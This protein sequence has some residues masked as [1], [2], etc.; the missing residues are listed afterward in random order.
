MKD[1]NFFSTYNNKNKKI[2]GPV[3]FFYGAL[4]LVIIG[5]IAYGIF[6]FMTIMRLNKDLSALEVELKTIKG[7]PKLSVILNKGNDLKAMKDDLSKLRLID[8]HMKDRDFISEF[9]LEDVR[10]A[11]PPEIFLESMEMSKGS[12]EIEGRSKNKEAIA[13]FEHNLRKIEEF[14]KVFVTH[15]IGDEGYYGFNLNIDMKEELPDGTNGL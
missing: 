10:L 4:V 12:I 2:R 15:V 6:N 11:I 1:M 3:F 5:F 14:K 7:N 9:I 13:Q 8:K